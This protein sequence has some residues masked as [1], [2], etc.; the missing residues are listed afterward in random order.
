MNYRTTIIFFISLTFSQSCVTSKPQKSEK[1]QVKEKNK[2]KPLL[3]KQESS[4]REN[5]NLDLSEKD[6]EINQDDTLPENDMLSNIYNYKLDEVYIYQNGNERLIK[7][8]IKLTK[9]KFSI[10]FYNYDYKD[11]SRC[12]ARLRVTQHKRDFKKIK[13]G[14]ITNDFSNVPFSD[15]WGIAVPSNGYKRLWFMETGYH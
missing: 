13:I 2:D 12:N 6:K 4:S 10:R 11:K 5:N 9:S 14:A 8:E 1:I 7:E 15:G 3:F